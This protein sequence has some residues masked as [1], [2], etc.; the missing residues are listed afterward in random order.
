MK[1]RLGY[2]FEHNAYDKVR[3]VIIDVLK[4]GSFGPV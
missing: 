4:K 2:V 3:V 1:A